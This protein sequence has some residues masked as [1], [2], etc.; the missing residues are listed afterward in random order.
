LAERVE[1]IRAEDHSIVSAWLEIAKARRESGA[2]PAFQL[3]LAKGELLKSSMDWGEAKLARIQ[4]WAALK[5]LAELPDTPRPLDY[6]PQAL[7]YDPANAQELEAKYQN[8]AIR[9]SIIAKQ[10]LEAGQ[11]NVQAALANSRWSIASSYSREAIDRIAKVGIAYKFPNPKETS[12]IKANERARVEA[13]RRSTEMAMSE[14]DMRFRTA[15]QV[16]Q[17][18]QGYPAPPDADASLEALTLRLQEGKDRPSEAIPVRRQFLEIRL[19]ELQRN[20][21]LYLADAELRTLV[22]EDK[23]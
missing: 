10:G 1:A 22:A 11:A 20:C 16:M 8:G 19:A 7:I 17:S 21:A 5:A 4:A 18:S 6:S 9:R 13:S 23:K 15:M 3:E 2:D 14:L 12:A